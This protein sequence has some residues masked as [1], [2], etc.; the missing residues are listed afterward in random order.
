MGPP[1]YHGCKTA[2]WRNT[3]VNAYVRVGGKWTVIGTVCVA[4]YTFW[5][6]SPSPSGSGASAGVSSTVTST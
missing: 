6:K 4:C 2:D 1:R 3:V 5:P